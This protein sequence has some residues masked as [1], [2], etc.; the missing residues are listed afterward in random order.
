MNGDRQ[1]THSIVSSDMTLAVLI[2]AHRTKPRSHLQ[3]NHFSG[4]VKGKL[5]V[6]TL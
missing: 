3:A 4:T 1:F 5:E 2:L 6:P